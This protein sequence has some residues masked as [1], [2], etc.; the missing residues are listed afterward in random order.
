MTDLKPDARTRVVIAHRL[1][2][3][4]N[5]VVSRL[6]ENRGFY[7]YNNALARR[8]EKGT[9]P[10]TLQWLETY[11]REHFVFMI[12]NGEARSLPLSLATF[13]LRR[14]NDFPNWFVSEPTNQQRKHRRRS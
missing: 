5:L 2:D 13:V 3:T 11:L 4:V 8:V 7:Q 9:T 14:S 1:H 6:L 10:V 12:E